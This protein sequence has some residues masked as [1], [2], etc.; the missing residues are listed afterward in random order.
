MPIYVCVSELLAQAHLLVFLH[1]CLYISACVSE[2]PGVCRFNAAPQAC[3]HWRMSDRLHSVCC[4]EFRPF[5]WPPA[6]GSLCSVFFP[7]ARALWV[8]C[9]TCVR[10]CPWLLVHFWVC[11]STCEGK[12]YLFQDASTAYPGELGGIFLV[13]SAAPGHH[14]GLCPVAGAS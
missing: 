2:C 6:R 9:N 4:C 13:A 8:R 12:Q 1:V 7:D 5:W 14:F 10:M 11:T 3:P